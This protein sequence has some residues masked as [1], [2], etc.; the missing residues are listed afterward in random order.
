MSETHPGDCVVRPAR[1]DDATAVSL[2]HRSDVIAWK[3]WDA[4]GQPTWS[5]YEKLTA[6]ERWMN[7]GPW[8]DEALCRRHLAHMQGPSRVALVAEREGTVCAEAEAYFGDEP[9]PFGKHLNLAVLYTRRDYAGR[10]LGSALMGSLME[11][12]RARSCESLSLSSASAPGFYSRF[13]LACW[14]RWRA[15]TVR[16]TLRNRLYERDSS[17]LAPAPLPAGWGMALGRIGSAAQMWDR[18]DPGERPPRDARSPGILMVADLALRSGRERAR[19]VLEDKPFVAGVVTAYVWTPDGRLSPRMWAALGD[20]AAR[21]GRSQMHTWADDMRRADVPAHA[22][23]GEEVR[24]V[25]GLR[26]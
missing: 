14:Q 17:E 21:I 4:H 23:W 24:E 18:L 26:L 7:G 12:A 20:C 25:W 1:P 5:H 10:G 13:G 15:L 6:F 3:G 8:M 19:V 9:P 16:A 11:M 2:V 22:R